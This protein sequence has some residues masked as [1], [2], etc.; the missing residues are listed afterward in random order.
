L[1]TADNGVCLDRDCHVQ[2]HRSKKVEAQLIKYR[3]RVLLPFY[4]L[5]DSHECIW[6][7]PLPDGIC[8][9]GGAIVE[10]TCERVCGMVVG[11]NVLGGEGTG[12]K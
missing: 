6:L 10:G 1:G 4:G 12:E 9:C 5:H 2:A 8:R 3:E 7:D 11:K